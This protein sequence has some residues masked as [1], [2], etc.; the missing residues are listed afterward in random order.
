VGN[1]HDNFNRGSI[2]RFKLNHDGSFTPNGTMT[3]N[4]LIGVHGVAFSP[5]GELFADSH[6]YG[7]VSRFLF[8]AN[9]HAV[10][11]GM[12]TIAGGLQ[13]LAF[14][15]A[16]ELFV[17]NQ[18]TRL[19]YRFHFDAS[20]H[21]VANGTIPADFGS[22]PAGIAFS[23]A[24]ELFVPDFDG[25][26]WRFQF[27]AQSQAVPNGSIAAPMARVLGVAF[28]QAGEMFVTGLESSTLYRYLFDA[29]GNAVPN[30]EITTSEVGLGVPAIYDSSELPGLPL[31]VTAVSPAALRL[32]WQDKSSSERGFRIQSK[33]GDCRS[34]NPWE[35]RAD[36]SANGTNTADFLD[37]NLSAATPYAYQVSTYF[38]ANSFSSYSD[39]ASASTG[40]AGT[41]HRATKQAAYSRSNSRV[42]LLWNDASND[43]TEFA[44]YRQAGSGAWTLLDTVAENT[45]SYSDTTA[46][47]ND[48]TVSFHYDIRACNA[49]GCSVPNTSFPVV[50]FRP[51]SLMATDAATVDLTWEDRSSNESKFEIQRKNGVC[52]SENPWVVVRNVAANKRTYSD[53]N[54]VPATVYS[55]RV[56]SIS[57]SGVWP[58]AS[59]YSRFTDCVTVTAP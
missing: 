15:A 52:T 9:G 22:G 41:P 51:G 42:D 16:G 8:D 13:G 11:N 39:C 28:S 50:P 59:G 56:R 23:P 46:T 45:Q 25:R 49:A 1:R 17:A 34:T 4:G 26:V 2:S 47:G 19:I 7:T 30:G 21:P 53:K 55:Y 5:S 44:I 38:G 32:T 35:T 27:N 10:P 24:G 20:G 6:V 18:W 12:F 40:A 43:E 57:N 14:N 3:G 54:A 33:E 29:N 36:V 31:E 48:T 58:Q 37:V